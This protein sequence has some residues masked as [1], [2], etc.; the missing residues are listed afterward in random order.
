M[1]TMDVQ[2][3]T[4]SKEIEALKA[5]VQQLKVQL[6]DQADAA[7]QVGGTVHKEIPNPCHQP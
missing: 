3:S 1:I 7:Q 5:E 4:K 6:Y 2:S